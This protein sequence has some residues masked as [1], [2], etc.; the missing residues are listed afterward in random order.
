MRD[1]RDARPSD[2]ERDLRRLFEL[3]LDLMCVGG[4]DGYFKMVNPAFERVLGIPEEE[5]L[6]RRFVEFVHE[7]D[8]AKTLAEVEHL[9]AG[10]H[11]IDFENRYR[12]ADGDYRWLAWRAAPV[13]ETGQIYAVARD[14][15]ETKRAREELA[16]SNADLEQFAFVASHDLRAPLRSIAHLTRFIES[17]LGA[18]VAESTRKHLRELRRRALLMRALIDDLLVFSRAGRERDELAE[19]D[20][21][22]LV[23]STVFLLDPPDGFRV[24]T[25]GELPVIVAPRGPLE[26]VV[27][28]LIDNAVKHH[29]REKGRISVSARETEEQWEIA[30]ADDGP[31]I[32]EERRAE[33]LEPRPAVPGEDRDPTDEVGMGLPVIRRVVE[34]CGGRVEID[35]R[36]G[37]G[38]T[39][40]SIWPKPAV[41]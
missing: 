40:R 21:D 6:S 37:R 23:E 26:Q 16:R 22:K 7:E 39:V 4:F 11:T 25:E 27:R 17:D 31:G 13:R 3:S 8:V 24:E 34:R 1:P 33:V 29:D 36:P 10:G 35:A 20:L 5:L 14:V 30:I 9:A 32:P 18:A 19:I 38:T 15:T 28:N 12:T 41:R 2:A